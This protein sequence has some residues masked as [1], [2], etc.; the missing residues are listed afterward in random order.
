MSSQL[1]WN[2]RFTLLEWLDAAWSVFLVDTERTRRAVS[3]RAR[4]PNQALAEFRIEANRAFLAL[5]DTY[6]E[7][8]VERLVVPSLEA[9]VL[10]RS[11]DGMEGDDM[12][13]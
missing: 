11:G 12:E 7:S 10:Q 1:W 6:R 13:E 3:I 4:T 9:S 8:V 5:L 2:E